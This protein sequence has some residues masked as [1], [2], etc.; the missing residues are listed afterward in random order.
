MQGPDEAVPG[1]GCRGREVRGLGP[2]VPG[3]AQPGVYGRRPRGRR[4]A[5]GGSGWARRR[6]RR[7]RG[8]RPGRERGEGSPAGPDRVWEEERGVWI[9]GKGARSQGSRTSGG[10]GGS[11]RPAPPR[12]PAFVP[13]RPRTLAPESA[14]S[15]PST[16]A[17]A[18]SRLAGRRA[19]PPPSAPQRFKRCISPGRAPT[20]RLRAGSVVRRAIFKA[21]CGP[22]RS[23]LTW[24]GLRG[25]KDAPARAAP[26]PHRKGARCYPSAPPAPALP[27]SR[28]ARCGLTLNNAN[29]RCARANNKLENPTWHCFSLGVW[30]HVPREGLVHGGPLC[31]RGA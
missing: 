26:P 30:A 5:A 10:G 14:G 18:A 16:A 28:A 15:R 19:R 22:R 9:G 6:R 11:A 2:R 23:A 12:S 25:Q 8:R 31:W 3:A 4:E 27:R 1:A 24:F 21:S 29:R 17:A 7:R 13:L 20:G